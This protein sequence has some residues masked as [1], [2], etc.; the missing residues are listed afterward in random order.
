MKYKKPEVE[1]QKID[2]ANP[3]AQCKQGAC[4]GR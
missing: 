2:L 1:T 4:N 3:D